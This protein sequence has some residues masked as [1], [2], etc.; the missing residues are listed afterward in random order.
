M[1]IVCFR[2]Y[3]CW[4]AGRDLSGSGG[5]ITGSRWALCPDWT[6]TMDAAAP[7]QR[8]K[9]RRR[10]PERPQATT[11]GR[12]PGRTGQRPRRQQRPPGGAVAALWQ[13]LP[14]REAHGIQG[15]AHAAHRATR[16]GTGPHALP[17]A[18]KGPRRP[19]SWP[20]SERQ[21][22][23]EDHQ[24]P[25]GVVSRLDTVGYRCS[26]TQMKGD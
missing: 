9:G 19:G 21:Q 14:G 3:Q 25:V 4:E 20:R 11:P 6:S 22:R 5:R 26:S 12:R 15:N 7:R 8:P 17:G 24:Q 23:Q 10:G 13:P 2:G 1:S 16:A 18:G